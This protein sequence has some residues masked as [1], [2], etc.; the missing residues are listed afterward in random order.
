MRLDGL[1]G[2]SKSTLHLSGVSLVSADELTVC[3]VAH[4]VFIE[5]LYLSLVLL[6]KFLD[7]PQLF[8]FDLLKRLLLN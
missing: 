3:D 1:R 4:Y 2:V 5:M 7:L 6:L 8:L